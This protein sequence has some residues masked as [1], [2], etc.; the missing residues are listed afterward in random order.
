MPCDSIDEAWSAR[1]HGA[2]VATTFQRST[3]C[4]KTLTILHTNDLHN[5]LSD[6]QARFLREVK[7]S[8]EP[9][10]LL[11]DAGDAIAAG[12]LTYRTEG[13][14]ILQRMN[15]AGYD[16]MA[17]GNREFHMTVT[18]FTTKLS[19]ASF[20][21]LCA[22]V[23]PRRDTTTLPCRDVVTFSFAEFGT[24]C[25]FGLTV[26][27][28][29]QRMAVRRFSAYIFDDP[30]VTARRILPQ[31][32]TTCDLLVC[33]SHLGIDTDVQLA[34]ELAEL[35]II[36]GGHSHTS[37]PNGRRVGRT[38]I[39]QAEPHAR[40]FGIT[41]VSRAGSGWHAEASLRSFPR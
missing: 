41:V 23:R 9:S 3:T 21:I 15:A 2:P 37:L 35:D 39:V 40:A 29:T 17:V 10:V 4:L 8:F 5:H 38:L 24:V 28:I 26:P 1:F 13:E 22:N 7:R 6:A 36:V 34:S 18:G 31:L 30:I 33:V 16:A 19:G 11:L 12:N 32:R 25:L 20:P 27:M 14:P